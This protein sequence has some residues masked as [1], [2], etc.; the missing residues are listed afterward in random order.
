MGTERSDQIYQN[1]LE[2]SMKFDYFVAGV[3]FALVGYVVGTLEV[4][5]ISVSAESLTA[6]AAIVLLG[7]GVAGLKRIE[8]VV[9]VLRVMH[10]LI[11]SQESQGALADVAT[12]GRT[13][14]NKATGGIL[15]PEEALKRAMFYRKREEISSGNLDKIS[16][17]ARQWYRARNWLLGGG[18]LI[19]IAARVLPAYM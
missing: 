19:L 14:L 5:E 2:S 4:A 3:A 18:L 1:W 17:R 13:A 15:T 11:Y 7:S 16:A 12:S 8:T 9:T 6:L 10:R